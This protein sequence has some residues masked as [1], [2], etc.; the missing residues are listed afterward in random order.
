MRVL[1]INKDNDE[2]QNEVI[3]LKILINKVFHLLNKTEKEH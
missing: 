2:A 1:E 3:K